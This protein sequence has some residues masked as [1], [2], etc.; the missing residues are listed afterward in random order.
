M[1]NHFDKFRQNTVGF[2]QTILTP[3]GEKPLIYADW[4]ASGR[5]Y[6]PIE[7][8]LTN[9]FGPFIGNTHTETSVTGTLMTNAYHY[10]QK[11]IKKHVNA[12]PDDVILFAGYGMTAVINKMQR[13]LGLNS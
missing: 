12:G 2:N 1:E 3:Y 7:D 10:A 11:Q 13:I 9:T 6:R 8:K 5:L 4:I